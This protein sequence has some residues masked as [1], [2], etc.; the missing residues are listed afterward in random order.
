MGKGAG[1]WGRARGRGE[2]CGGVGARG[3]V[4][5][6]AGARGDVGKGAGEERGGTSEGGRGGGPSDGGGGRGEGGV[7]KRRDANRCLSVQR[8]RDP[9]RCPLPRLSL[10]RNKHSPRLPKTIPA[11]YGNC[12]HALTRS[13]ILPRVNQDDLVHTSQRPHVSATL[14]APYSMPKDCK[15]GKRFQILKNFIV[16]MLM[17][18]QR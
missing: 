17:L 9:S 8:L 5:K 3:R 7:G 12:D 15:C 14:E 4:G 1:A 16:A 2:G 10:S 18:M 11:H 13:D 6:G